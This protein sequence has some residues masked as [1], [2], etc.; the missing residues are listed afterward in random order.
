MKGQISRS[1]QETF[2][3]GYDLGLS[4]KGGELLCFFGDLGAGKTTF[5]KGIV[6]ACTATSPE[7]VV[8]PT[9]AYLNIYEGAIP[10]YHFDLYRLKNSEDFL[11][12]GFDEFL[13]SIGI[14]CIEW[15][16]RI[17]N[18]LDSSE[19]RPLVTKIELTHYGENVRMINITGGNFEA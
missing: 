10:V 11:G 12:L 5:I 4:L 2:R 19:I 15:S 7:N 6:A 9:Y 1:E 18:L 13:F 8:S 3:L 17:Q 14:C 16:E